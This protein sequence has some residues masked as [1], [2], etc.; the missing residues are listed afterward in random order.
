MK[1]LFLSAFAAITCITASAQ[2]KNYMVTAVA[3]YNF[4]NLFD[5]EDDPKNWG[6]DEF[7]PTGPY[8]YTEEIYQQKLHNLATVLKQLGTEITPDG[9]AIIG[10]AEIENGRVLQDLTQQPLIKDR[11]YKYI[12]FD[13]RDSRGIDVAMLYSP[14]YF[15]V[16]E[17]RGL[18]VDISESGEKGGRTRDILYVRGILAGDT[19]NVFVNHWPSRRGGEAASAPLRALAASVAKRVIDSLTMRNPDTRVILMGDLNDDPVDASVVKVLGAK[20]DKEDVRKNGLYNPFTSFYKN[21]IGTLGYDDRWNLFDQIIISGTFLKAGD[22]RWRYY[23]AEVFNREFLK[24]KFGQWKGYPHRS[25]DGNNWINGYSDHF[26]T[27]IY[28]VKAAS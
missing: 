19:V 12:H 3:F 17:A 13:S 15:Q 10:T 9:P 14:K 27:L 6:D 8:R 2:K 18:N 24:N 1:K 25:F 16:L 5:T 21:G 20:G 26:P 4:E 11:N 28:L 22:D 23:K 7:L